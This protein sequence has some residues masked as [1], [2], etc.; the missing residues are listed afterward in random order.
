MPLTDRKYQRALVYASGT[1]DRSG[2]SVDMSQIEE[3]DIVVS[4]ATIAAGAVTHIAAESDDNSSFT[5]G[6]ELVGTQIDVADDDDN[7]VFVISI[8]NPPERYVR[9]KV[10]KD[11][12]NASAESAVYVLHRHGRTPQTSDV[13]NVLTTEAHEWPATGTAATASASL[14]PSSSA[15][16]SAS[17]SLSPSVSPSLSSSLSPSISPSLSPSLSASVSVSLSDSASISLSPS[18][19][20]SLSPSSTESP[21]AT[22][23]LS[24]SLS[25]SPS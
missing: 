21:S 18:L 9:L 14:S 20:I 13:A 10:D 11:G 23:S 6:L 7:Q 5:S 22:E 2:D 17:I 8:Q 3:I 12:S 19:S 15:S 16:E 1:G 4:F 24:P 25:P